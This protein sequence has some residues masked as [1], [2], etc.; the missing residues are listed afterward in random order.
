MTQEGQHNKW[1]ALALCLLLGYLG[2]HRFYEGKIFTG[3]IWL[4]TAGLF[5]VGVV[6][7]AILILFKPEH[8]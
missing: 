2:I 1:V 4:C 5:G 8:Y 6:I 3:V 7:D